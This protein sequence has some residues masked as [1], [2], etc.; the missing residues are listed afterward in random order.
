MK[1][2]YINPG[3]ATNR[4]KNFLHRTPI[5][6]SGKLN[7]WTGHKFY[8]KTEALQKIGAFKARGALN[9]LLRLKE[10]KNL[11]EQV[12]SFSSGNHAQGIAYAAKI[13]GIKATI[14]MPK[15]ASQLKQQ[16]T[17]S[18][19]ADLVLCEDRMEAENKIQEYINQGIYFIHPYN[20]HMIIEGQSTACYE[21]L[22][23]LDFE[24][25]A[26]FA[27]CG[28]G[29]LLSGTLI[30]ARE[31]SPK[32]KVIGCEPINANDAAQSLRKGEITGFTTSPKTIA[33]GVMT[34]KIGELNFEYLKQLDDFMEL[35]EE[36]IIYWTQWL[37]HLLKI[38]IEPSSALAMAAAEQ[39]L[40]R[41]KFKQKILIILSG[42]NIS[43][44][45][46][47]EIWKEDYLDL[48]PMSSR[49]T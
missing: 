35:S 47:R 29:G 1:T 27:P 12:V 14:L 11:P 5:L 21:A 46:H 19:G 40:K 22:S 8:F 49:T 3:F 39:W 25:D 41:Q 24:P 36:K 10:E 33:D 17:K 38:N 18:Y 42:G 31:L 23:D 32:S 16:A 37:T 15:Q 20:N 13:L 30:A 44:D 28:G 7:D 9:T 2:F 26:I 34:L 6:E 45:K 43:A 4:L 48:P